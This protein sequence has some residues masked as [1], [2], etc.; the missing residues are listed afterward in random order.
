[1]CFLALHGLKYN[2]R[3]RANVRV[4]R[5]FDI[6]LHLRTTV[7]LP[8][9]CKG[10]CR[11]NVR[12]RDCKVDFIWICKTPSVIFL[13]QKNDSSLYKGAFDGQGRALFL[14]Y[15]IFFTPC[16]S[17]Y[18]I[19]FHSNTKKSGQETVRLNYFV[20]FTF[21]ITRPCRSNACIFCRFRT[22]RDHFCL[23]SFPF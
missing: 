23:S 7:F 4:R 17:F 10:R 6:K 2:H 11:T 14:R 8:P 12:R 15:D 1:M 21:R 19:I 13:F 22:G 5:K 9:L 18:Y 16:C 3:D 20:I